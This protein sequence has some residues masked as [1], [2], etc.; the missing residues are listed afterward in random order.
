MPWLVY[1]RGT[2]HPHRAAVILA[3]I[4]ELGTKMN[5]VPF[6]KTLYFNIGEKLYWSWWQEEIE[7]L[8]RKIVETCSD[9]NER[10]EHWRLIKK[11]AREAIVASDKIRSTDLSRLTNEEIIALYDYLWQESRAAHALLTPDIDAVDITF[12]Q[13][14][15]D[16]I[17]QELAPNVS[18]NDFDQLYKELTVPLYQS[19]NGG[20]E[21]ALMQL[22]AREN[23][24]DEDIEKIYQQF[25]WLCLGWETMTPYQWS[26]LAREAVEYQKISSLA[27]KIAEYS[28]QLNKIQTRREEL[29]KKFNLSAKINYWLEFIDEY[30]YLH[31]L[32]KEMQMKTLYS[33][34]LLKN[35]TARRFNYQAEDLEWLLYNEVKK[36][37]AGEKLDLAEVERRKFAICIDVSDAGIFISSGEEALERKN[38]EIDLT[39]ESVRE[40][41]GV[42][43]ANGIVRGR[44]KVCAGFKEALAKVQIGDVL[45]TGMT[46]PDY[47]PAVKKAAA[48]ITDEGGVT[49]HAAIVC[50]ELGIPCV[51]GTKIAT[52]VF[53][54]GDLVEVD[55]EKGIIKLLVY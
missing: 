9:I 25:W 41:K 24:N 26:D 29:I 48:V 31:D 33:F 45:I 40:V 10:A 47:L 16:L 3:G 13:F 44:V 53:Q 8:G 1:T 5:N 52:R 20:K 39:R 36:I 28:N 30:N 22:A 23:L 37:L 4:N 34:H 19:K 38:Q 6:Q 27:D 17:K 42:G 14:F 11:V 46:L 51:V 12:D 32:R 54:D 43:V 15:R 18:E 35:E 21:L 55:A 2:I 50:R 49:C 7:N